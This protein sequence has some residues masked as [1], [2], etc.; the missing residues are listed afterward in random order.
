MDERGNLTLDLKMSNYFRT[1]LALEW[2]KLP[3]RII[4]EIQIVKDVET[5]EG[6]E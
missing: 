4:K 2:G 5:I 3:K 1:E 6:G